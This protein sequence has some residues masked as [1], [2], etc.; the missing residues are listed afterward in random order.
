LLAVLEDGRQD[1]LAALQ[2]LTDAQAS[3]KPAPERWSPLECMEHIVT[4]ED[5]F[6]GWIAT[7]TP[8]EPVQD[9]EKAAKL[10]GMVTDRSFKA[11][12]PEAVIPTGERFRTVAEAVEAFNAARD[13]SV[14]IVRARGME[15]LGVGVKHGRFGEMNAAELVQL[16]AGHARRHAAQIR[17]C[18]Q[19]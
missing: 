19:A 3:R 10:F 8:I 9:D 1:V 12:A 5:R 6:L 7:G 13:R 14:Q 17:E 11:Q 2:G 15:L 18:V 4:V 16:I